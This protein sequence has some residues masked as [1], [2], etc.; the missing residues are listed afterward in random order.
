MVISLNIVS[1]AHDLGERARRHAVLQ[2]AQRAHV[3]VV[4]DAG[5]HGARELSDLHVD[6]PQL[7]D[8]LHRARRRAPVERREP[9]LELVVVA[10]VIEARARLDDAVLDH[11][12][13]DGAPELH[14]AAQARARA[15][16]QRERAA[17]R[18]A[19]ADRRQPRAPR[20]RAHPT[21]RVDSRAQRTEA[22]ATLNDR[23]RVCS[24]CVRGAGVTGS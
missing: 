17:Q 18:A 1:P 13:R 19:H 8:D 22:N 9:A 24:R 7:K 23:D 15:V 4:Q 21:G 11:Q 6:A 14:G 16:A 3:G 20:E 10:A 2:G 12:G 5:A